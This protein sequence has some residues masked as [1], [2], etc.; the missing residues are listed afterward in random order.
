[1][2][3]DDELMARLRDLLA[4]DD[5]VPPLVVS[6][7]RE[8]LSWRTIDAE[9]ARLVADSLVADSLLATAEVR[10]DAARLLTYQ[11]DEIV[12]EVEVTE[13]SGRLRVVGQLV[14]PMVARVQAEQ[15]GGSVEV[16]ADRLGRFTAE[17]VLRGP[18]RFACT[19]VDD[20]GV[21]TGPPVLTEW[22]LL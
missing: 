10:G 16:H 20:D 11:V 22:T 5:P 17:G 1:M 9:L 8:S 13:T 4:E 21:Q 6:A 3:A 18:T 14:P 15:P 19:P 12:I 7:A 2:P